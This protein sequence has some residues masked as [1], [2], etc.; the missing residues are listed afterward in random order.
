MAASGR[1][2]PPLDMNATGFDRIPVM[3]PLQKRTKSTQITRVSSDSP[4]NF[5]YRKLEAARCMNNESSG[6]WSA[7]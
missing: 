2:S 5:G 6:F 3:E 7:V 4:E 1:V